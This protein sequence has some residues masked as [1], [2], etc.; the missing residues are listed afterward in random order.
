MKK[1]HLKGFA[2]ALAAMASLQ[3]CT[4]DAEDLNTELVSTEDLE[5]RR[6]EPENLSSEVI[7]EWNELWLEID[8]NTSGMRPCSIAR[9]MAYINLAAY[10]TAVVNMDDNE[11]TSELYDELTI[12]EEPNGNIDTLIALNACYAKAI[13]YFMYNMPDSYRVK[14]EDLREELE[15]ELDRNISRNT[16][17][18]SEEWGEA[19]AQ[20]VIEFSLTDAEAEAQI[21]EP[22]PTSYVPPVGD[23][24]WTFSAEPERAL[25]PYWE[26]V[27]TFVISS[28]ETSSVPPRD[29]YSTD[30][31]SGYYQQMLEVY[32]TNN[33]ARE[34]QNEDL[35]IAEF[36]S[37][38]VEGLMVSPPG[39]QI[40]LA[41]Q[42]IDTENM[43]V[44]ESLE[45]LLKLGFATN[46]AAVSAW[47]DKYEHMV[48]RPSNYIKEFIDED[49]QT[50]LFKFIDWLNPSF[51]G[52]P[53]GHSTFASAAA[54]VFID[55]VGD[56][57]F[58]DYSHE[59]RTEFL[60]DP[61]S[62]DSIS[63]MAIENAFS[64]IPLG[65]HI[66][67]DCEEGLRLGYEI[68]DAVNALDLTDMDRNRNNN[69]GRDNDDNDDDN[70]DNDDDTT[71]T[72]RP[73][74]RQS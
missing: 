61:R 36:W 27:R 7:M 35:W 44:E 21:L 29:E 28:E 13:D 1:R 46:D 19:V 31:N 30:P 42:F 43:D 37:D 60:S 17:Q 39:R 51:P 74:Q 69:A 68:S 4:T 26:N 3:S 40:A 70:E 11:S 9:A 72:R 67:M 18:N 71:T 47:A 55:A 20:A 65:V 24:F 10:E 49:F 25:F 59:G 6:S 32:E 66:R 73:L 33:T 34:E 5:R 52:Y 2:I 14:I 53:S 63:E 57:G 16:E 62:F 64:R 8:E 54:G 45:M 56:I 48:M 38:D 22:Q 50:N 15:D 41:I 58:T 12:P 23:G